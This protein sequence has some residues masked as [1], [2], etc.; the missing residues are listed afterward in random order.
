MP[1][2]NGPLQADEI[3]RLRQRVAELEGQLRASQDLA[4]RLQR[5]DSFSRRHLS[6]LGFGLAVISADW[7]RA[8]F[9]GSGVGRVFG[10]PANEIQNLPAVLLDSVEPSDLPVLQMAMDAAAAGD[11]TEVTFRIQRDT[12]LRWIRCSCTREGDFDD[13]QWLVV[14]FVDITDHKA[15]E[16]AS[17][18]AARRFRTLAVHSP[19]GIFQCDAAGNSLFVND[20][21]RE[22]AGLSSGEIV[23]SWSRTLHPADAAAVLAAW[24]QSMAAGQEFVREFRFLRPDGGT[25]WVVCR[26]VPLFDDDGHVASYLGNLLDI[27]TRVAADEA[28]RA[29]EARLRL[30]CDNSPVGIFLSDQFGNLLYTNERLQAIYRYS[31]V[32]LTGL[33]VQRIWLPHERQGNLERWC[34][35]CSTADEHDL[36]RLIVDGRGEKRWIHVRSVPMISPSGAVTG[37]IGTVEDITERRAAEESLRESEQ[38][39][40]LLAEHATD[41]ITRH[42]LN[43]VPVYVSPAS[44]AMLG[45]EPE[46]LI[47]IDPG[48]FIHPD[49]WACVSTT[50][51]DIPRPFDTSTLTYRVRRKDGQYVWFETVWTQIPTSSADNAG[52]ELVALSRDITERKLA[53]ER[54]QASEAR[55]RAI[56]D[57]A[58]DG[59]VTVDEAGVIEQINPGAERLFGYRAAEVLGQN[60]R[61]L[62]A[63]NPSAT[64][65]EKRAR[66]PPAFRRPLTRTREVVGRRKDGTPVELEISVGETTVGQRTILTGILHDVSQ[67]KRTERLL[68]ESEKLAATGRIAARVAHE[69]NNPLAGIKNSF[70]L[71]KDSIPRDAKYYSFVARIEH[72]IDRVA[73]IVRQMFD[74]YRPGHALLERS[75]V[76][77][78]IREVVALLESIA[79]A[80]QITLD[81]SGSLASHQV[82]M[83]EDSLR[84][85]LYNVIINA[86]EASPPG[87]KV[88]IDARAVATGIDILVSDQGTGIPPDLRQQVYEPFFTTKNAT[89]TGGLGLGLSISRSIVE[90][91]GGRLRFTT[92]PKHGTRFH[93]QLPALARDEET[94]YVAA[95]ENPVRR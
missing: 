65:G 70:L 36:D 76:T 77:P 45:Y 79:Q 58:S 86:I 75:E 10:R 71:V 16:N 20:R 38:R 87:G 35:I 47:G 88:N 61:V 85:V 1:L 41:L 22:L 7:R 28:L 63:D 27:S 33:G 37:R 17:R 66:R 64:R 5:I 26:A 69:I 89:A 2:A 78:V 6:A 68:R 21:F 3:G 53:A 62:L 93:I 81:H 40:R 83:S 73:R 57:T 59:I 42:T 74:L 56:L 14:V 12:A 92:R 95:V 24:H 52:V 46:E 19:T 4:P 13:G 72:E 51:G 39:Y 54:L 50:S 80:R 29:S 91:V 25:T 49:D 15:S 55:L 60:I 31:A 90:A 43:G 67:R 48:E 9:V 30:L 18:Q 32:E 11:P 23:S 44:R 84:Q 34:R 94:H 82:R 8:A